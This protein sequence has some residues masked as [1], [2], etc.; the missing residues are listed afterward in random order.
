MLQIAEKTFLTGLGAL[1]LGREKVKKVV[2]ELAKK[3]ETTRDQAGELVR[4]LEDKGK[5]EKKSLRTVIGPK[6]CSPGQLRPATRQDI[7]RLEQKLDELR[8]KLS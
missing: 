6:C 2:D 4:K 1:S 8:E 3:G 5:A 7:E